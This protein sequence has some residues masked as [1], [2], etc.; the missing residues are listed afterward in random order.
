MLF[1]KLQL[2]FLRARTSNGCHKCVW[3]LNTSHAARLR[4]SANRRG[5]RPGRQPISGFCSGNNILAIGD[6]EN[7][8]VGTCYIYDTGEHGIRVF[9]NPDPA[10]ISSRIHFAAQYIYRPGNCGFKA[11]SGG[12]TIDD[13]PI[14][15]LSI[16]G[17]YVED[18]GVSIDHLTGA[19]YIANDNHYLLFLD[20]VVNCNV[21]WVKSRKVANNFNGRCIAK[22]RNC[23]SLSIELF[24]G[25]SPF[26]HGIW[27]QNTFVAGDNIRIANGHVDNF[28]IG[29]LGGAALSF[30]SAS[31]IYRHVYVDL[32]MTNGVDGIDFTNFTGSFNQPAIFSGW[33][34]YLT[35]TVFPASPP[36]GTGNQIQPTSTLFT[37]HV[38][39]GVDTLETYSAG[40]IL[41][42]FY[43]V[44]TAPA[45]N[46]IKNIFKSNVSTGRFV[47]SDS[48]EATVGNQ[49]TGSWRCK[50][51][52]SDNF[53]LF[54][55]I[56]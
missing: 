20:R 30:A 10:L 27:L 18:A 38:T 32:E 39:S 8:D 24:E 15:N 44:G 45:R 35:G 48:G 29:S 37:T 19:S 16:D 54:Q 17:L 7:V 11:S 2:G 5:R 26:S 13:L 6:V 55:R 9:S 22:I 34:Q 33:Y 4:E 52:L 49:L 56:A 50:G 46:G 21:G 43:G 31:S 36:S 41:A 53:A 51:I 47:T 1:G 14:E 28:G 23:S 25:Y 42:V 3:R 12:G 40:Q